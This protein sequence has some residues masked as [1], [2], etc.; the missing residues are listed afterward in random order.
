VVRSYSGDEIGTL[1]RAFNGLLQSLQETTVTKFAAS[2]T[3][4]AALQASEAKYRE[5]LVSH[6]NVPSS[7]AWTPDGTVTYF[8]EFAES[9]LRV[10]GRRDYWGRQRGRHHRAAARRR[11]RGAT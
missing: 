8:N 10:L 7:C 1:A 5:L 4:Y 6:A 2:K 11:Y 9:L 3:A